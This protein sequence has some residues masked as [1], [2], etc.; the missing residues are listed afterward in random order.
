MSTQTDIASLE[1]LPFDELVAYINQL[2]MKDFSRL[3]YLLYAVDVS[4]NKLKQLLADHPNE[5]AGKLIALLMLERQ[6]QKRK[7]REQFKKP[8]DEIPEEERW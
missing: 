8:D 2:I 6:E 1:K 4:E 7:T 5:D 3:V